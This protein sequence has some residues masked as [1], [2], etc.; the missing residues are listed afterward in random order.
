[1]RPLK[2]L[3]GIAAAICVWALDPD[4]CQRAVSRPERSLAVG[5]Q[6]R[7]TDRRGARYGRVEECWN[8]GYVLVKY[9][10]DHRRIYNNM[11]FD[12][13]DTVHES[14]LELVSGVGTSS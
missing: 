6:V 2:L 12:D 8:G 13:G 14:A 10:N 11:P 3:T 7:R 9:G 5:D 4:P 1:M